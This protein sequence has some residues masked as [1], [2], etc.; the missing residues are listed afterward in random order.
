LAENQSSA[1][2]VWTCVQGPFWRRGGSF[3]VH[4][5]Q[6][7][8]QSDRVRE[9][10]N[11]QQ[12]TSAQASRRAWSTSSAVMSKSRSFHKPRSDFSGPGGHAS[13][14]SISSKAC[15][16]TLSRSQGGSC[17]SRS[18]TVSA[19]VSGSAFP[20]RLS[21]FVWNRLH[22]GLPTRNMIHLSLCKEEPKRSH[23]SQIRQFVKLALFHQIHIRIRRQMPRI[24]HRLPI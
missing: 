23:L 12:R 11:A 17:L 8:S 21:S 20:S 1:G 16:S 3:A 4:G 18:S 22:H 6:N 15:T 9:E 5:E 10:N 24:Q 13:S 7:Y 19:V 14:C 2:S